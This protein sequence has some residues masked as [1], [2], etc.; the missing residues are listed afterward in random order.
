MAKRIH[1]KIAEN[2][3][4]ICIHLTIKCRTRTERGYLLYDL[5][6]DVRTVNINA[7]RY[8][9]SLSKIRVF[10]LFLVRLYSISSFLVYDEI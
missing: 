10:K 2:M 7:R 8:V 4:H 5:R 1:E 9:E 6:C 3:R